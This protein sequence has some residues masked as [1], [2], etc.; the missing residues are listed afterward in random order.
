MFLLR[1][2]AFGIGLVVANAVAL[3]LSLRVRRD[4]P[5]GAR[6]RLAWLLFALS[7]ATAMLRYGLLWTAASIFV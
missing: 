3:G 1:P 7:C 2:F 4:F 6:M 5:R